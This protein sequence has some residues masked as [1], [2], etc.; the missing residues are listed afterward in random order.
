MVIG[1]KRKDWVSEGEAS[2]TNLVRASF[3]QFKSFFIPLFGVM[4]APF[5]GRPSGHVSDCRSWRS[6]GGDLHNT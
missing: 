6:L 5:I 4:S 1:N 2:L 3:P